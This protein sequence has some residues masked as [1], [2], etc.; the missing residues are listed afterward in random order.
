M[1]IETKYN[2]GQEVWIVFCKN[3]VAGAVK[4]LVTDIEIKQFKSRAIIKYGL[5]VITEDPCEYVIAEYE[6]PDKYYEEYIFPTK[7]ELLK[8][9]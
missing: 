8:S 6:I 3:G 1:T 9:L 4:C 5:I 7:E 2:I